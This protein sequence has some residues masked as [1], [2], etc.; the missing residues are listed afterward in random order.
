M[1][2]TWEDQGGEPSGF[3]EKK[4]LLGEKERRILEGKESNSE[5]QPSRGVGHKSRQKGRA[6]QITGSPQRKDSSS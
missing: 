3:G 2:T 4:P 6:N 5:K 1:Q